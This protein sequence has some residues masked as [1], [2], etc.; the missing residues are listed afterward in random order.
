[1]PQV[2]GSGKFGLTRVIG[3]RACKCQNHFLKD[4]IYQEPEVAVCIEAWWEEEILPL[5]PEIYYDFFVE[6]I[7]YDLLTRPIFGSNAEEREKRTDWGILDGLPTIILGNEEY[8]IRKD[9]LMMF[10]RVCPKFV[11]IGA[12][13]YN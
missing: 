8:Y 6:L 4:Y 13:S 7:K 5:V 10:D 2:V 12:R 11:G 1:M 3:S 9:N